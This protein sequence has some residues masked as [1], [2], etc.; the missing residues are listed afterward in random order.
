M[1]ALA[2]PFTRRAASTLDFPGLLA[3]WNEAYRGYFIPFQFDAAM[4]QRHMAL[5]SIDLDRSC[6]W[7]DGDTPMA[8]ALSGVRGT[9]A[10][11]GGWG[12]APD[13]RGKR[14]SLPLVRDFMQVQV[15]AGAREIDLE[16]LEQNW[17]LRTYA[18]AGFVDTRRLLVLEGTLT[19]APLAGHTPSFD[20]AL[21][22]LVTLPRAP[23][24]WQR[25]IPA[26][27]AQPDLIPVSVGPGTAPT[28]VALTRIDGDWLRI[29]DIACAP[30]ATGDLLAALAATADGRRLRVVNE[31]EG[32]L[33]DALYAAGLAVA[34]AQREMRWRLP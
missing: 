12:I 22:A 34:N 16:A 8:V 32:P 29:V 18:Q 15:D 6:V 3:I 14:H 4:L 24:C 10:W 30:D 25:D 2:H 7:F 28:G 20:A 9:R 11:L 21:Q 31:P 23:A 17:A 27:R 13:W 26:L 1:N 33:A 19:C 5:G